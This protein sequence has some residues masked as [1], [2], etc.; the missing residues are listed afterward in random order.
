M[1]PTVN[2]QPPRTCRRRHRPCQRRPLVVGALLLGLLGPHLAA[3]QAPTPVRPTSPGATTTSG[4]QGSQAPTRARV[5]FDKHDPAT[6]RR[7]FA[8]CD[9]D[10]DDRL[11]LFEANDAIEALG[12]PRDTKAFARLDTNRD[13][14]VDWQE[15]DQHFQHVVGR[16]RALALRPHRP[17]PAPTGA[18]AAPTATPLQRF[19]RLYDQNRNGGLDPDEVDRLASQLGLLPMITASLRGLDSNASGKIEEGELAPWFDQIQKLVPGLANLGGST[20]PSAA[21]GLGAPWGLDDNDANGQLDPR[22]FER[23]LRRVDPTLARWAAALFA[24]LDRNGDQQLDSRELGVA[25]AAD[26]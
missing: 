19:F 25:R 16:G 26:V 8:H 11:D 22:E 23:A 2:P 6:S 10:R 7:A 3:Q 24:R 20:E 1:Y 12:D 14:F 17:L 21:G 15:F 18:P 13:G 9:A 4:S 5:E